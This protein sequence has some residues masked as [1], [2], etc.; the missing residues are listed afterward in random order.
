MAEAVL[1]LDQGTT[2]S[3]ALVFSHDGVVLG[4]AYGEISQSYPAPGWVEQDPLEIWE[5]SRRVMQEAVADAGLGL[6]D[7]QAIGIANQ[8][9]TTVVWERSTGTPV[10]P[11]IVWQSRQTAPQ[12]ELMTRAGLDATIRERTGLVIDP[13]FSGSKIRWVLERYPDT[14]EKA[15]GGE[16]L[17]GTIDTWLI[18]QLTAGAAHVTDPTNA[19]RTMLY[20]IHDR[21]WDPVLLEALDIPQAMLPEVR[22]SAGLFG[23]TRVDAPASGVPITGVAGDQQAA[24]YGQGCWDPGMGKT[25][26]GTGA[27]VVTN[28]GEHRPSSDGGLLTTIACDR[29]GQPVYALEGSI[30]VAGALIQWFRDELGLLTSAAESEAVATE[31]ASTAGVYIVPAFTGLG[32]PYWDMHARGAILGLTRGVDRRHLVRA[33]LEAIAY[34]TADVVETMG[35]EGMVP[36]QELRVD[37]GACANNFLMQFQADLLGITIDRPRVIETTATGAAFLA[38]LGSRFWSTPDDIAN[39]RQCERRFEPHIADAERETLLTGWRDAVDRV[40]TKDSG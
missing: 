39:V 32:A 36:V 14:T 19:S 13:Y 8:R 31:V 2:G 28:L 34:Q 11:A 33:A 17:F 23:H 22:P 10:H 24:L 15:R 6:G 35:A 37:G 38:G 5:T 29:T 4:R 40:R 26:Y 1:A 20:N 16:L 9:E 21:E 30:F 25:T 18:W 3:T 12:C 7:V 27:F